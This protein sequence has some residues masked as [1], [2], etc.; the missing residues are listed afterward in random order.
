MVALVYKALSM[1]I[2]RVSAQVSR[3]CYVPFLGKAPVSHGLS[4]SNVGTQGCLD[5]WPVES[6]PASSLFAVSP[7][8]TK[9][10]ELKTLQENAS[11][12]TQQ[13]DRSEAMTA[14]G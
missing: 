9:R 3:H 11:R 12:T 4:I 8:G 7:K 1:S 10:K 2:C 5:G 14:P 13:R 6:K